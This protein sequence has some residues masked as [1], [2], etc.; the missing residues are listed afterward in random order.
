MSQEIVREIYVKLLNEGT[1]V[2]RPVKAVQ[3]LDKVYR[4]ISENSDPDD[5]KWAFSTG[6]LVWC[7]KQHL[8]YIDNN[9]QL[10]ATKKAEEV[11]LRTSVLL[12]IHRALLGEITPQMRAISVEW[13]SGSIKIWVYHDGKIS[14]D[15]IEDFDTSVITQI[16]ADF[17]Q[18]NF[19]DFEF[20]R[21]DFP[22]RINA[23]EDLVFAL[24][25]IIGD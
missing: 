4:I 10:V 25:E 19:V 23:G 12:S 9:L 1:N 14:S 17:P 2:W 6:D 21:E 8:S 22:N 7:S 11:L 5:E 24:K 13:L 3:V 18:P 20:I 15:I 16:Y